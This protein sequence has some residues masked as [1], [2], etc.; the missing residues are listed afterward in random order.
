[1]KKPLVAIAVTLCLLAV[2]AGAADVNDSKPTLPKKEL[3]DLPEPVVPTPLKQGA[4]PRV[5][6]A[7]LITSPKNGSS[8]DVTWPTPGGQAV[9]V[10]VTIAWTS[11]LRSGSLKVLLDGADVTAKFAIAERATQATAVL[12]LANPQGQHTI[13][14]TG[15]LFVGRQGKPPLPKYDDRAAL[16]TFTYNMQPN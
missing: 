4:E 10:G 13:Q 3:I 6:A 14:A 7:L 9:G 2:S 8:T 5:L 16:C 11:A 12:T 15:S 1:M